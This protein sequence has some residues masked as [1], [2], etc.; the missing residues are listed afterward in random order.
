MNLDTLSRNLKNLITADY[1]ETAIA[2]NFSLDGTITNNV[3]T[4]VLNITDGLVASGSRV[5]GLK[6]GVD[7]TREYIL[8]FTVSDTFVG[9]LRG[10][11]AIS[12]G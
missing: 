9:L 7:Q 10:L 2:Y 5:L 12:S 8:S 3:D 4:G 11:V 6:G 1:A